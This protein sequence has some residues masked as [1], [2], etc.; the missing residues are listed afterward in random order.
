MDDYETIEQK[1]NE[2]ANLLSKALPY[3]RA[4]LGIS[5]QL[6]GEKIGVS[7]QTISSIERSEYQ[8]PWSVFLAIIY[9]LKINNEVIE[10]KNMTDV[11]KLL[12]VNP[13]AK[14]GI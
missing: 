7:R 8:M 13:E 14:W 4:K 2:M 5:Q 9:F 1:Q 12:L 6:L 10:R 11:D 3:F